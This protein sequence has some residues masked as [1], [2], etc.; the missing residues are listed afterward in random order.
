MC[1]AAAA[2]R[3]VWPPASRCRRRCRPRSISGRW[4]DRPTACAMASSPSGWPRKSNASLAA[5]AMTQ[6]LRIGKADVL[7]RHARRR[8]GPGT[9][10]PRRRQHAREIIQR[11]IADRSRAPI[12]QRRDQVVMA[13]GRFVVDRRAALQDLL[14]LRGIED[15]VRP[16]RT[17]DLPPRASAMRLRRRRPCAP[18]RRAP[19]HRAA[20]CGPQPPRGMREQLFDRGGIEQSETPARARA[21]A[22]PR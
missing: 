17:P 9:A 14:Q 10:D 15:F 11:G 7:D 1:W 19:R 6:R 20:A 8:G 22:A 18:A 5:L 3:P 12:M 2:S 21:T 4:R 13:V 16:R